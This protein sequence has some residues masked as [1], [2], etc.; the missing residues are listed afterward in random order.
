MIRSNFDMFQNRTKIIWRSEPGRSLLVIIPSGCNETITANHITECVQDN[1]ILP[2]G[3]EGSSQ[4]IFKITPDTNQSTEH[5]VSNVI[6]DSEK[7]LGKTS[8]AHEEDWLQDKIKIAVSI[9]VNILENKLDLHTNTLLDI[10]EQVKE[11][12]TMLSLYNS[13]K[14]HME[15]LNN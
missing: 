11:C 13:N 12:D 9:L 14:K 10:K 15:I 4:K 2:S 7:C 5:F 1:F 8:S 3:N 6:S